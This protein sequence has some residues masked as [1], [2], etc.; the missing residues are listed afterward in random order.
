[1][2]RLP[3]A[4]WFGRSWPLTVVLATGVMLAARNWMTTPTVALLYLL[5]VGLC[6]AY[7]GL[8]PG[9][10]AALCAFLAFNFFFLPPYYTL[11]ILRPEDLVSLLIFL[12][13]AITINSLIGQTK[14]SLARAQARE[15]EALHLHDLTASLAGLIDYPAILRSV[16]EHVQSTFAAEVVN[17]SL[18]SEPGAPPDVVVVPSSVSTPAQSPAARISIRGLRGLMGEIALW[19][20]SAPL[21][22]A[23]ERVLGTISREAA[24]A[25]ER[26]GLVQAESRAQALAQSDA[27]KSAILSSVSHELRSP[28]ATIKA[29]VSSLRS[30]VVDWDSEARAQLLAAVDEET[31]HLNDLVGY[32]LDMSRIEAGSLRPQ[33][34]WNDLGEILQAVLTR[35]RTE[36]A[37]HLVV[38]DVPADMPLLP[39][40][41]VEIEQVLRNLLSNSAKFSPPGSTIRV[42]ARAT[43]PWARVEVH[44]QGPPIPERYL[45]RVFDKFFRFTAQDQVAGTGLGLSICKGMVEAHG[46]RIWV[47]SLADGVA[48]KFL[49]PLTW[50]GAGPRQLESDERKS[51]H[52]GD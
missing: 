23:E 29:S 19:R 21:T 16:A 44:N 38:T 41:W 5:P 24:L 6:T 47:E 48:F 20:T 39:V 3:H 37:S 52:P 22:V 14:S 36:L 46:G 1:M 31:D 43:A 33:R 10:V 50:Q 40:D 18:A 42:V 30:S 8:G 49:L 25:V 51:S 11:H 27:L 17:V 9:L 28:L 32:L 4:W 13:V 45:D 34:Q 26:V 15:H 7:W 12:V 2:L 35:M